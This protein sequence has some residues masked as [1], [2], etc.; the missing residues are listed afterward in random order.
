MELEVLLRE[1]FIIKL[2]TPWPDSERMLK[3]NL[4]ANELVTEQH[5]TNTLN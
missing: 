5:F 1:N 3:L 4:K 2:E